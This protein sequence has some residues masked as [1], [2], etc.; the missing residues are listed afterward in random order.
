VRCRSC[1]RGF[2]VADAWE[3]MGD[4]AT[5]GT[6]LFGGAVLNVIGVAA[7]LVGW[8]LGWVA[9]CVVGWALAAA[10]PLAAS[11][12]PDS[13]RVYGARTAGRCPGCDLDNGVRFW[14][15]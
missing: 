3:G 12:I 13:L 1:G 7:A 14:S 11:Y 2:H 15:T 6:L 4:P 10:L 9:I 5:P 8:W